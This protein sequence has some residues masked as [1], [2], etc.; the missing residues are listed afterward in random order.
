MDIGERDKLIT[1]LNEQLQ[2]LSTY[3]VE[4][5]R[6]LREKKDENALLGIVLEDY[7]KHN[8]YMVSL[9]EQQMRQIEYLLLYL[10]KSMAEAGITDTMLNQSQME[11]NKL[12]RE[13]DAIKR[14]IDILHM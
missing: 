3:N 8:E 10:E 11:R 2:S 14:E 5:M 6:E 13:L 7:K 9:K 1:A 4:R 12:I